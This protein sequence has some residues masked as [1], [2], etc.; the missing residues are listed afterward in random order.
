MTTLNNNQS[1]W[2]AWYPVM[3]ESGKWAWLENVG[4]TEEFDEEN[5]Y[6]ELKWKYKYYKLNT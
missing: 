1:I 6:T 5:S 2:F 4:R 3:T